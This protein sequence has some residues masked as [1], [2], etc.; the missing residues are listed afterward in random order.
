MQTGGGGHLVFI[1]FFLRLKRALKGF[2]FHSFDTQI[3]Q[4]GL[5]LQPLMASPKKFF[6]KITKKKKKFR[7]TPRGGGGHRFTKLFRKIEFFSNDGFP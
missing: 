7:K 3:K 2:F 5:F 4:V 1:L 6:P